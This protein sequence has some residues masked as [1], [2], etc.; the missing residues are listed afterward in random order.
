MKIVFHERYRDNYTSDP[1]AAP[2]RLDPAKQLLQTKYEFL[3]PQ[4]ATDEDVLLVHTR[5]HLNR[6]AQKTYIYPAALLAAGGAILAAETALEGEPAFGLIR[7]PGHHASPDFCWGFCWFNNMAIAV[8]R[9]IH[10]GMINT[11]YILD[12]DLHFG[13]G[14]QAFFLNRKDVTYHHMGDMEDLPRQLAEIGQCDI[15]GLSAGFDRH[16]DDWGG[17]LTTGDYREIG[18]QVGRLSKNT[19]PGRVFSLLEGGYNH[20]VLGE[21]IQ[22]LLE[23]L[24]ESL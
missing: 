24:E 17:Y 12:F 11:A 19:C 5:S 16:V 3:E 7:P 13:D 4:P 22:A 21:N 20:D 15:I 18:R 23:G 2:G 14:T 10:N 1:A 8:Q 6:I 9:L